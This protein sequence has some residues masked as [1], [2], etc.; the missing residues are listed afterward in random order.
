MLEALLAADQIA[1]GPGSLYTSVLAAA[2][3]PGVVEAMRASHAQRVYV[4]NLRPQLPE[5]AGYTVADHVA[6]LGRHGVPVDLVVLDSAAPMS[7][8]EPGVDYL[9]APLVT[10]NHLVHDPELLATALQL[11]LA[12]SRVVGE[13][14]HMTVRVG[15]NG[16]GRIGKSFLRAAI[17]QGADLEVVAVND[18]TTP[19][20]H[21]HLLKHDSILGTFPGDVRA[22]GDALVVDGHHIAVFTEPDPG[23]AAVGGPRRRRRGGV[24]GPLH[25]S[26]GCRGPPRGGRSPRRDLRAGHRRRRDVRDG[27]ERRHLRPRASTSSSRTRRARRTASSRWSRCSTTPSASSRGS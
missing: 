23:G 5:T 20:V 26:R 2:A 18:V 1:I 11:A 12:Q 13:G 6:A 22:E 15:I 4:C 24:D 9:R 17:D 8:G 21:A 14:S 16:F 25:G 10:R 19:E 27:R 3:V 7:L